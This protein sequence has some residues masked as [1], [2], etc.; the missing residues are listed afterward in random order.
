MPYSIGTDKLEKVEPDKIKSSLSEEDE[1]KLMTDI[2]ELY[3]QLLPTQEIEIK[4]KKL[5]QKLERLFSEEW[6]GHDIR[7]HLFG[8]SGNLLCSDDSDVDICIT[9][10]WKELEN[11]CSIADLLDRHGMEKV[12]CVSSAKVPIVKMWDPELNLACDMNVNNTLALE[13]TRMVRTY[14]GI[15]E[16]VRPLAMIIK[17]WTRRRIV[18]DAAFGGTLSSYTWICLII[19]FLQQRDP[20]VVPAL[21]Q[22][23]AKL[24]KK[25]G[26]KSEFADD[27]DQLRG[28]GTKNKDSLAALLF[29]FFRYYAHEFDYDK[30]ALSMRL[31]KLLTKTEKKWH[32]GTNNMLCIEE[33]FNT[34]RNLGNTADDTS[35]RGLHMELRRA[36]DLIA[37]GKLN[38]CCEQFVF[39]KE[40]ERIWQKPAPAPRPILVR[41]SSQQHNAGRGR[42]GYRGNRQFRNG[43]SSRRASS[44]VAYDQN[45]A[46]TQP[47]MATAPML[48]PN[49]MWYQPQ[50]SQ[51]LLTS[52]LNALSVQQE[53]NMRVLY[54]QMAYAQHT[55]RIQNGSAP[56]TGRSRTDSFDNPPLS[57][58]LQPEFM[59]YAY[60][61]PGQG[62][63]HLGTAPLTAYPSSP[64]TTAASEFRR[65]LHRG[66]MNSDTGGSGGS[67]A[68]RSQSQPAS[69]TPMTPAQ[70]AQGFPAPGHNVQGGGH[71]LP[72]R[73]VNGVP[74][75]SFLPDDLGDADF[76]DA[77]A[78]VLSD[79]PP[80]DDGPR[81]IGYYVNESSSPIRKISGFPTPVP[82]FGDLGQGAQGRRRLSTDQSPQS[83]LDRR[84]KRTNSRSPSPLGHARAFSVGTSSAPLTSA[85]FQVN[86][87][88][89]PNRAPLVVNGTIS[90]PTSILG[91]VRS[92]APPGP[93]AENISSEEVGF[94]NPLYISQGHGFGSPWTE[95]PVLPPFTAVEP[96]PPMFPERPVIVNG[97]SSGRSP[98]TTHGAA[99]SSFQHRVPLGGPLPTGLPYMPMNGETS[100]NGVTGF[101]ST[102]VNRSRIISRQQ[103]NGIAPLDLATGDFTVAQDIQQHLSP[104]YEH[105]TPS[106]TAV[107]RFDVPPVAQPPLVLK[108]QRPD[109]SRLN[110]KTPP[111][112][113]A[114]KYDPSNRSPPL[115][116]RASSG[117]RENGHVRGVKSQ[118]E[119]TNSW[120][121]PKARKKGVA[122]LKSAANGFPHG[123]QLPKNDAD[124]KGG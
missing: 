49:Y 38:D 36:F 76:D 108:D 87:K 46:F 61:M 68:L 32:L 33:P 74:I 67:G 5:V 112:G 114:M 58:P 37:E 66:A 113:P 89:T 51:D 98:S 29:Q 124:R 57:A 69:R 7:V 23:R 122:D 6:P 105:R 120:Q 90:K 3:A 88:L 78:K 65:S 14:V 82:A 44:S 15:D 21:H 43:G 83:I 72:P 97:S 56:S 73:H 81:P 4:R 54:N 35:F 45:A 41:S 101:T 77:P 31:G 75:P 1:G 28:Y 53:H 9:T 107:R 96:N 50:L 11:V 20:P 95:Q 94:D 63:Y 100:S 116:P 85:P 93:T 121:R 40:E 10:P 26:T 110:Q 80:E 55:Q 86:G 47:G 17:Y 64:A 2:Q 115:D 102:P 25:D 48:P 19:A 70:P 91:P 52:S 60:G 8:S 30:Y 117:P 39:P 16:R 34:I 62:Y 27:L 119:S 24:T 13:N 71:A 79:S 22:H 92:P 99:D 111:T 59:S 118:A 84:M 103:Q 104:V 12:V 109:P 42:G 18:N 106:P 123:E